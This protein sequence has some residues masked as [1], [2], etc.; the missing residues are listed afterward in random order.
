MLVPLGQNFGCEGLGIQ[1]VNLGHH[2]R[3][4]TQAY[5]ESLQIETQ[6]LMTETSDSGMGTEGAPSEFGV[7]I[8]GQ[9]LKVKITHT[10]FLQ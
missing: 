9:Y 3:S 4:F 5:L 7:D 2:K 1:P 8:G 6:S 10:Y